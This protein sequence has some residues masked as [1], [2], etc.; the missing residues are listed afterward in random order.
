MVGVSYSH[1][2]LAPFNNL[3]SHLRCVV[4]IFAADNLQPSWA[5]GVDVFSEWDKDN[6][7]NNF[8]IGKR[9]PGLSLFG[10]DGKEIRGFFAATKNASMNNSILMQAFKMMVDNGV[11]ERGVDADGKEYYPT[12]ILDGHIS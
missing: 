4:M 2:S 6:Y 3:V 11:T 10:C 12:A 7:I 1:Y 9:H 5:L 8:G